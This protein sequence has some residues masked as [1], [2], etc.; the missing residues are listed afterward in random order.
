[1]ENKQIYNLNV[2]FAKWKCITD[3]VSNHTGNGGNSMTHRW[4][5][6]TGACGATVDA[7]ALWA[8]D[9]LGWVNLQ[10]KGDV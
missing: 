3:L 1:M 5:L 4:I 10:A 2:V 9:S 7:A 8:Y 6:T